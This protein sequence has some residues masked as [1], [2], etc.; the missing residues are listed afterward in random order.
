VAVDKIPY[1]KYGTCSLIV[2]GSGILCLLMTDVVLMMHDIFVQNIYFVPY[3]KFAHFRYHIVIL[4]KEE[5]KGIHRGFVCDV[6]L[7]PFLFIYE[8]SSFY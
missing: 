2:H 8:D 6:L 7:F 3:R 1:D 5:G 4:L